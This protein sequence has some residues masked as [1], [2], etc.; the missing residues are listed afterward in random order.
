M[1]TIN[2]SGVNS[3]DLDTARRIAGRAG[4]SLS[5]CYQCGKCSAGCP[6]SE[7]MDLPPQQ[8]M[9][10]L[11]MGLVDKALRAKAP[12]ICAGC[13]V[14]S[15]RCPQ[16]IEIAD[17]MRE[18]RRE[19]HARKRPRVRESNV[20]ETQFIDNIAKDGRN[21]EQYLAAF[22]NLKSGHFM[23]DMLNAPKMFTKGMVGV[24]KHHVQDRD[25]VKRL[26]DRCLNKPEGGD[27]Q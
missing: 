8:V 7:S 4:V 16:N 6:M 14:C 26:V 1:G 3:D 13:M 2:L 20:F 23:Q 21:N 18:V 10:A 17:V 9:R 5:D 25:A 27:D 15:A 11:Q 22:Y 12:W 24:K 19:S